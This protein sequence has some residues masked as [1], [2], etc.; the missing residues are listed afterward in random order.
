MH[1]V[2]SILLFARRQL[3]KKRLWT[4]A[5]L[6][7]AF[8]KKEPCPGEARFEAQALRC[9]A[10]AELC[11]LLRTEDIAKK[12]RIAEVQADWVASI[13]RGYLETMLADSMDQAGRCFTKLPDPAESHQRLKKQLDRIV[14][15]MNQRKSQ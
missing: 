8:S 9:T 7:E 3:A 12:G 11:K 10:L 6:L 5:V 13:G 4:T 15:E 2:E 14:Q 1:G